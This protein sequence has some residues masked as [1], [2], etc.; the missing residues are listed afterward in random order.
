MIEIT[1]TPAIRNEARREALNLGSLPGS[2]TGGASNI[3]GFIGE[4]IVADVMNAVRQNTAHYDMIAEDKR[5][6]VKSKRC[7]T[8]PRL[9]YDCSVAAHGTKQECDE[10]VFVR[11]LN[12][13]S[14]AWILGS[15]AKEDFYSKAKHWK[16]GEVDEDNGF[17]IKAD[18][19]NL[20]IKEL[21][22]VCR[23]ENP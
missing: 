18:C 3:I 16:K 17:V 10:Y 22:E 4:I 1:L 7:N 12:D 11:V 14:K 20:P 19:Y 5:I 8:V 23:S 15:I 6:D 21:H 2:I 13:M 9:E